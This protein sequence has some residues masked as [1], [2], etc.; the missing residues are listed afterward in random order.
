MAPVIICPY[1]NLEVMS[2]YV[3]RMFASVI[4]VEDDLDDIILLENKAVGIAAVH[5]DI[6]C[7][8]TGRES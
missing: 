1:D 7:V 8:V 4:V 5:R 6:G 2:V 3:K